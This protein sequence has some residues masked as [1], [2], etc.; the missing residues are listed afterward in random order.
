MQRVGGIPFVAS[1]VAGI[2]VWFL[3]PFITG[4]VEPWD[5][6]TLY[7]PSACCSPDFSAR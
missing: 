4:K 2:A 3:S 7:Y 5:S 6:N 1:I